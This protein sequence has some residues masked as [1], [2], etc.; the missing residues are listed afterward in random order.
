M[1]QNAL[2]YPELKS[3]ADNNV[4]VAYTCRLIRRSIVNYAAFD[5]YSSRQRTRLL[6]DQHS[7][8]RTGCLQQTFVEVQRENL[9][10]SYMVVFRRI[11][12]KLQSRFPKVTR[13][14]TVC[15]LLD[16]RTKSRAK[17][18]AA[19]GDVP[20]KAERALYKG[21]VDLLRDEQ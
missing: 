18:I 8:R 19:V 1:I 10:S 5:R 15:I 17:N 9:V 16:P 20:H 2:S 6:Y 7:R 13:E 12:E 3:L 4:R 14:S 11:A 21:G